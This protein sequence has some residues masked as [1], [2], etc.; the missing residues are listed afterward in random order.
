[1]A[2]KIKDPKILLITNSLGYVRDEE[3]FMDIESVIRQEEP[4]VQIILSKI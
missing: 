2:T 4:Y 1:M 3:D